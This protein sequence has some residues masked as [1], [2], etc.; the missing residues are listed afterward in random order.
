MERKR[1]TAELIL[2]AQ[3]DLGVRFPEYLDGQLNPDE[4]KE[5][6]RHLAVCSTCRRELR[7]WGALCEEE[8]SSSK[9]RSRAK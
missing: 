8:L 4:T 6:E 5:I 9:T 7:L 3:P 1:P 2:C